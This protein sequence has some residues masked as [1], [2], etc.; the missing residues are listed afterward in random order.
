MRLKDNGTSIALWLSARDT[1][2]WAHRAGESWPCSS[3]ADR[4]V[5]CAFDSNGLYE[6]TVDGKDAPDD[7]DANELNAL[8]SDFL[9]RRLKPGHPCY[10]VTVGQFRSRT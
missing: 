5:F 9:A 6:L 2:D 10:L 7:I 1:Y 3:L 8:T 4:R